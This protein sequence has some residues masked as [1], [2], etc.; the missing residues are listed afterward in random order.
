LALAGGCPT[1]VQPGDDNGNSDNPPPEPTKVVLTVGAQGQGTVDQVPTGTEFDPGTLV[2]LM[3]VPAE[4]WSFAGWAGDTNSNENPLEVTLSESMTIQAQFEEAAPSPGGRDA[5]GDGVS[6]EADRCPGTPAGE[7]VDANGCTAN[8]VDSDED[9]VMDSDD[10]CPDT[11]AGTEVDS[12]GC[13]SDLPDSDGDGVLNAQDRCPGTP[14]GATVNS[15]GCAP[16]QLDTDR[17]GVNNDRDQCPG[18]SA[19]SPVDGNGCA[20]SQRDS[21]DDGVMDGADECPDTPAGTEVDDDGCPPGGQDSDADGVS[22]ALD[23]C[24]N[25]APGRPVDAAGCPLPVTGGGGG[26]GGGEPPVEDPC[27]RGAGSCFAASRTPGCSDADCCHAVCEQDRYCC[28]E[29]WDDLCARTARDVCPNAPV[30]TNDSCN[31]P[32]PV[33]NGTT[34]FSNIGATADG[35]R[36]GN[37]T[38]TNNPDE[39]TRPVSIGADVW[40]CYTATC[41]GQAIVS[42]CGSAY[43]TTMAVYD[44][45]SCPSAGTSLARTDDCCGFGLE[46]RA[47]VPVTAGQSYVIRIGGFIDPS[48]GAAAQGTG[49]MTIICDDGTRTVCGPG[50]GDCM[51]GHAAPGC[52]DAGCCNTVCTED[53]YCCDVEWDDFCAREAA[54]LCGGSFEACGAE[55]AGACTE[56]AETAGC[57]NA[58]C[59]NGVCQQDPYCCLVRWDATCVAQAAEITAC[60]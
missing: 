4:G 41:T 5:D 51:A 8:Q 54:G 30:V 2:T 40:F 50:N 18:T 43:D 20:D 59:C 32:S 15:F 36:E 19:G 22:D 14:A 10:D 44:G 42:L 25:T 11:P 12:R 38:C 46:S 49:D 52:D 58:N 17:D 53:P 60:R 9:G 27:G 16:S 33:G 1:A 13:P 6:D 57:S 48:S 3:A 45:C 26:G 34:T 24:A 47:V 28:D 23:Q 31:Q 37:S 56:A 21:D 35:P 7:T 55:G 29:Q 39:Q